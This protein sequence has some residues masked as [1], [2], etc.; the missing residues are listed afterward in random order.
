[1]AEPFGRATNE[2]K[3]TEGTMALN[4]HGGTNY[5]KIVIWAVG[6][7][8]FVAV[9]LTKVPEWISPKSASVTGDTGATTRMIN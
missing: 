1:M 7:V 2:E 6:L 4:V 8:A 3:P 5:G 9:A